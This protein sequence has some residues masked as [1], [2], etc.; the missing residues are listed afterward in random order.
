MFDF[1][2]NRTCPDSKFKCD[3]GF[4]IPSNFE[5]D[6]EHDCLDGSDEK[7]CSNAIT[8]KFSTNTFNQVTY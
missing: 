7:N 4:C 3:N 8:R 6:G 1:V 2:G 5:C